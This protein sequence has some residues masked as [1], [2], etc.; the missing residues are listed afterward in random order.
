MG[1][2]SVLSRVAGLFVIAA[3]VSAPVHFNPSISGS[4]V[5]EPANSESAISKL[6]FGGMLLGSEHQSFAALELLTDG[7]TVRGI[8]RDAATQSPILR[9]H[10]SFYDAGTGAELLTGVFTGDDGVFE[11]VLAVDVSI[12]EPGSIA[13]EYWVGSIYPNPVSSTDRITLEYTTPGNEPETPLVEIFDVLGRRVHPASR[14]ATGVYFYRVRFDN[15]KVTETR[16]FLLTRS[17]P[18][19]IHMQQVTSDRVGTPEPVAIT[20]DSP[21]LRVSKAHRPGQD[22][23]PSGAIRLPDGF[24]LAGEEGIRVTIEKFGWQNAELLYGVHE[25]TSQVLVDLQPAEAPLASFTI[26][27]DLEAGVPVTFDATG[28]AAPEGRTITHSWDFGDGRRGGQPRIARIYP[29]GGTY[30]VTLTVATDHG[31]THTFSQELVIQDPVP[32]GRTVTLKGLV[33]DAAGQPLYGAEV[34]VH[35]TDISGLTG[36]DGTVELDEV[37]GEEHVMVIVR[38]DGY[39]L[40]RVPLKLS[41]EGE[42]RYYFETALLPRHESVILEDIEFGA[43][44]EG[45]AGARVVLGPESLVDRNGNMVTGDVTMTITPVDISNPD[46]HDAFPGGFLALEPDGS[47]VLIVS[48][49]A[50]EYVFEQN[51]EQLQLAPGRTAIIEI[52]VF[53]TQHPDCG[54][55][56]EGDVIP[57]WSLHPETGRWIEEGTG[58]IVPSESSPTGFV[59][60]GEV[61]HFSWWNCDVAPDAPRPWTEC[62]LRGNDEVTR[63]ICQVMAKGREKLPGM[64]KVADI[65]AC[66][67]DPCGADTSDRPFGATRFTTISEDGAPLFFPPDFPLTLVAFA[68]G[69]ALRGELDICLSPG[70]DGVITIELSPV[71]TG[72]FEE[73]QLPADLERPFTDEAMQFHDYALN[74]EA[75][76]TVRL[77]AIQTLGGFVTRLS[78]SDQQGN[79]F[80]ETESRFSQPAYLAYHAETDQQLTVTVGKFE[81]G[82]AGTYRL[83]ADLIDELTPGVA[84]GGTMV[85]GEYRDYYLFAEEGQLYRTV[86]ITNASVTLLNTKADFINTIIPSN[87]TAMIPESGLYVFRISPQNWSGEVMGMLVPVRPVQALDITQGP[88]IIESEFD[89]AYEYRYFTLSAE[90]DIGIHVLLERMGDDPLD[91]ASLRVYRPSLTGRYG[92]TDELAGNTTTE[93]LPASTRQSLV[94]DDLDAI[95]YRLPAHDDGYV[96]MMRAESPHDPGSFRLS[97]D[98]LAAA[99]E[100]TVDADMSCP[101]ANTRSLHAALNAVDAGGT[102]TICEGTYVSPGKAI[103]DRP[104]ITVTGMDRENVIISATGHSG[105]YGL[106]GIKADD[107][108]L[109]NFSMIGGPGPQNTTLVTEHGGSYSNLTVRDLTLSTLNPDNFTTNAMQLG[110]TLTS[111]ATGVTGSLIQNV[112]ITGHESGITIV[113][114]RGNRVLDNNLQVR[115]NGIALYR[116]READI[117]GNTIVIHATGHPKGIIADQNLSG[118]T[119]ILDNDI[120][121]NSTQFSTSATG[122]TISE[123]GNDVER[124]S[125]VRRN[126]ILISHAGDGIQAMIGHEDTNIDID[127]N[128]IRMSENRGGNGIRLFPQMIGESGTVSITNNVIDQFVRGIDIVGAHNFT[129]NVSI[130]NNTFRASLWN[131]TSVF[132]GVIIA[133]A[134]ASPEGAL[135]FVVVNNI[136]EGRS[137]RTNPDRGISLPENTTLDGNF[138]LFFQATPYFGGITTTGG[139][140]LAESDPLFESDSPLLE[141]QAGSPAI[142]AGAGTGDYPERPGEDYG[143]NPRPAAASTIGAHEYM[144][145]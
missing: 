121:M 7:V 54:E 82:R 52:P 81:E 13:T 36:T 124:G 44:V 42:D 130:I 6:S 83:Q 38:R 119:R 11:A 66:A 34:L 29:E 56:T 144:E 25:L 115:N 138:N 21:A 109:E 50:A 102:V 129:S 46:A 134:G 85:S 88:I 57:M 59:Q 113:T 98:A 126:T 47:E 48:Y 1:M 112:H 133:A 8:V 111:S 142:G 118:G 76:T 23:R 137:G 30:T 108:T 72:D 49:G 67:D 105:Q 132:N 12:D 80:G 74:L 114:G 22:S 9:A 73:L 71:Q 140:D 62:V 53:V 15:N 125:E 100:F 63:R 143:G 19:A 24:R 136:F 84:V 96:L 106:I 45:P 37:P 103:M 70:H 141:L 90:T 95:S 68:N 97:V 55:I 139:D 91:K 120:E 127:R 18:V 117:I 131:S 14:L 86:S 32:T 20:T 4:S 89:Y 16:R 92:I 77:R 122:I 35:G 26:A 101:G 2:L 107:I 99:P 41:L 110:T 79:S 69:G 33:R 64:P 40:Q 43:D 28:S 75:G 31:G 60:R 78:L 87:R 104:G 58:V 123:Y 5:S 135:P 17:G 27:G 94:R 128:L 51:G 3:L 116:N 145:P 93:G 61:T 39:A 10:V 65:S